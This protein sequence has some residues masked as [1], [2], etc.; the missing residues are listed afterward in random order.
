MVG[1]IS[2][3]AVDLRIVHD[4]T[5][6]NGTRFQG[7]L[8]EHEAGSSLV[9][10]FKA[11]AYSRVVMAMFMALVGCM[12]FGG[13]IGGLHLAFTQTSSLAGALK[14]AVLLLLWL[15]VVCLMGWLVVWNASPARKDVVAISAA[16]QHALQQDERVT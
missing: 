15:A 5:R 13:L 16:V 1:S 8:V 3:D 11:S 14:F 10:S 12:F 7:C 6:G 9:G 4:F 2:E